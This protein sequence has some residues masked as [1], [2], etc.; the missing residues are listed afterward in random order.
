MYSQDHGG[1]S[2][3]K[4]TSFNSAAN[5]K[6]DVDL[7][8]DKFDAYYLRINNRVK[9]YI[10]Q[11]VVTRQNGDQYIIN[12]KDLEKRFNASSTDYGRINLLQSGENF[13]KDDNMLSDEKTDYYKSPK[14][15]YTANNPIVK[16]TNEL[17]INQSA[18]KEENGETVANIPDYGTWWDDSVDDTKYMFEFAGRFYDTGNAK[19]SVSSTVT[20]GG[21]ENGGNTSSKIRTSEGSS[22][23]NRGT[24]DWSYKNR[25]EYWT[26][27]GGWG[28]D[29]YK[30]DLIQ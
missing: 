15:S 19:A 22:S 25:Y 21:E 11:I 4:P 9:N 1:M 26:Y 3:I 18:T 24:N 5:I 13:T 27:S 2:Y 7:P 29:Y 12:S 20:I 17:K 6:M 23:A 30:A 10:K 8:S 14:S 28:T 16:A